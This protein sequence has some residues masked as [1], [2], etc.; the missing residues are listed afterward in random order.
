MPKGPILYREKFFAP[1]P[2]S[3]DLADRGHAN[4][5]LRELDWN[6]VQTEVGMCVE[7]NQSLWASANTS[8]TQTD[9][10]DNSINKIS[11]MEESLFVQQWGTG[12]AQLADFGV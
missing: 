2:G 7:P 5:N 9:V 1:V 4:M 12:G 3:P 11:I 8:I 6:V 10:T